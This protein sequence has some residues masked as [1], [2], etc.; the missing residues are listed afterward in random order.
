[1]AKTTLLQFIIDNYGLLV[2]LITALLSVVFTR[3]RIAKNPWML[4]LVELTKQSGVN[5]PGLIKTIKLGPKGLAQRYAEGPDGAGAAVPV[6]ALA[7]GQSDKVE[8]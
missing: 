2:P 8:G 7:N 4:F 6:P 1:M 3:E 5:V